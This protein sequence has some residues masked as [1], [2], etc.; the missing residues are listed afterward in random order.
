VLDLGLERHVLGAVLAIF[1][2]LLLHGTAVARLAMIRTELLAWQQ[3][4]RLAINEK[5]AST[6]DIDVEKPPLRRP[7]P[8]RK[9]KKR[10][11]PRLLRRR[12]RLPLPHP[13][14]QRRRARSSRRRRT[15]RRSTSRTRS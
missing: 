15:I 7:L 11:P 12:R 2:A 9:R 6:Y 13:P 1:I 10:R 8:K 5:L 14:R 4:L 3:E